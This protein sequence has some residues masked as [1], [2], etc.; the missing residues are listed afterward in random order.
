MDNRSILIIEDE[1]IIRNNLKMLLELEGYTVYTAGNGEEGLKVL[2]S[3]PSPCL[4]LLDIL[5]PI[6]NG[7]EF[8][9]AKKE[10]DQIASIPVCVVSGVAQ[11][12][13]N[14]KADVFVKK[15]V[16]FDKLLNI[17]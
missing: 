6:M 16:D 5:M 2:R 8:L 1:E 3:I 10:E 17:V 9:A 7:T 12:L 15:P 11:G 14:L 4:I 13:N